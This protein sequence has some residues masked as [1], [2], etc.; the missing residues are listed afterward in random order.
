M[1]VLAADRNR[2]CRPRS[3]PRP[4]PRCPT[5]PRPPSGQKERLQHRRARHEGQRGGYFGR[6]SNALVNAPTDTRGLG[7]PPL[8][9]DP[10]RPVVRHPLIIPR[11]HPHRVVGGRAADRA[12]DLLEQHVQRIGPQP[13]PGPRQRGD[14]RRPPLR[15]TPI[16]VP[17]D[18]TYLA[19]WGSRTWHTLLTS[20]DRR[21]PA[22]GHDRRRVAAAAVSDLPAGAEAGLAAGPHG[23]HQGRRAAGA[24]PRGRRAPPHQPETPPGL[25]RPGRVR[26]PHPAA[27]PSA[28]RPSPGHP[29][30][31]PA[32]APPP[33]APEVD[34]PEPARTT[35]DRRRPRRAGRAD[36]EGEPE[37]GIPADPGRAAQT[38][39]PGRRLDDP[40]DP[41]SATGSHRRRRGAPTPAGGSSCARRP[42]ACWPSTSSTSTAR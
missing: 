16:A 36:G 15:L 25:G 1:L 23:L 22:V 33:R 41:A 34:L 27:A 18:G 37:L 13:S 38:R 9:R 39:P 21:S 42:P 19:L 31:D 8:R 3:W 26:R 14:V 12:G 10:R 32:L 24:A 17:A 29:G 40:P 2:R 28:A 11:D 4:A 5:R 6:P 30:H 7:Q 20:G 35:T